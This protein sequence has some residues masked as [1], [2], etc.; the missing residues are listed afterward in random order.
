MA[1][2]VLVWR[3]RPGQVNH[4]GVRRVV[5]YAARPI[6]MGEELCYDYGE[7]WLKDCGITVV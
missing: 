2:H 4:Y 7:A 5:M 6:E 1:G 3:V